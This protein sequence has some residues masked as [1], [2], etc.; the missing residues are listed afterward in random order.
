MKNKYLI[1]FSTL[2]VVLIFLTDLDARGGGGSERGGHGGGG[3]SAGRAGGSINRSPSLSRSTR[4]SAVSRNQFSTPR[5]YGVVNRAYTTRGTARNPRIGGNSINTRNDIEQFIRNNPRSSANN[6][7]VDGRAT[8]AR[9]GNSVQSVQNSDLTNKIGNNIRRNVR[10]DYPGRG[11]WFNRGFFDNNYYQPP[12]YGVDANWWA[13]ASVPALSIWLG[14]QNEP[15]YYYGYDN[16]NFVQQTN[17]RIGTSAAVFQDTTTQANGNWL[18][19]GV[20]AITINSDKASESNMFIQL[21]LSKQGMISGAFY[22]TTTNEVYELEGSVN[23]ESQRVFWKIADNV[24]SP[25]V[26]AGLYNLTQMEVPVQ[27]HFKTGAV[28]EK[29]LVRISNT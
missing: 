2:L 28:Q 20:F 23:R 11:N 22:N 29:I 21:A 8:D 3:R 27:I 14:M 18:P 26:E 10:E 9:A 5:V 24:N 4:T 13:A 12:Y 19:L 6:L 7:K 16:G 25:V 17:N 15:D 1:F